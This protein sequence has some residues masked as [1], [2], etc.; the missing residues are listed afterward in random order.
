MR[1]IICLSFFFTLFITGQC[2][3]QDIFIKSKDSH[4]HYMGRVDKQD[5]TAQLS[6]P[7]TNLTIN[8]KG[9]GVKALLRDERGD[10]FYTV[11]VDG[12]VT[13]T[14][15]LEK[16]KKSYHLASGLSAGEHHLQLFKRTEWDK[17]KT[18]FYGFQ[19]A[20]GSVLL[21]APIEKK[22]K[23]EFFGNS[24]T[25]GYAVEDS[26]G[27]DRGTA[28]YENNYISYAAITARHFDAEYYCIAKSGIG[29][30]VSWFP[31]IMP[32]MYNRLDAT[33]E[34]SR[35]NFK[36]Y[37]PDVVVINLFQNDSWIVK[38]PDNEQFKARFGTAAPKPAFIIKAYQNM[39]VK[40]RSAYPKA[41]IICALGSMDATALGAPWMGYIEQAVKNIG[42]DKIHTLCFP[43]KNRP[44]HPNVKEQQDM[45]D[46]LIPYI[47]KLTGWN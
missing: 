7:G 9:T 17:G 33:D 30:M 21:P 28:P 3:G 10:N 1:I 23:I 27:K 13:G 31:L 11:I 34:H 8:F 4:I 14:I 32:E 26:S 35:W 41:E 15:H 36:N 25:C 24:I 19:L 2:Q 12:Q 45:A 46:L 44:G 18:W 5:N 42:D 43:Y 22:H 38:I 39:V 37:T 16:E 6:W 40:I 47:E 20:Q 29:V